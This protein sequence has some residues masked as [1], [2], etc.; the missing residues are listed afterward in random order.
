MTLTIDSKTDVYSRPNARFNND[1]TLE[2]RASAVGNCRRA[3]WYEATGHEVTTPA[4][5]TL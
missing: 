3:L 5:T 2:I 4:A 1:G